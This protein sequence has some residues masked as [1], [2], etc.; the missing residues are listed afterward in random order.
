MFVVAV[1]GLNLPLAERESIVPTACRKKANA[2]S[3]L[4]LT[5]PYRLEGETLA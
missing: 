2:K 1:Q 3:P 5:D 4:P